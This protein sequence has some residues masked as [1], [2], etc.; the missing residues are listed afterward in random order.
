LPHFPARGIFRK[1]SE[2]SFEHAGKNSAA[3]TVPK[4]FALAKKTPGFHH[5]FNKKIKKIVKKSSLLIKKDNRSP[6][7]GFILIL[8]RKIILK[9]YGQ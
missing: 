8:K 7:A 6:L 9:T 2:R 3:Q 5:Q 4:L 1:L